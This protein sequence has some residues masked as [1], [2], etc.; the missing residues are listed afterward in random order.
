MLKHLYFIVFF[1]TFSCQKEIPLFK[2]IPHKHSNISFQNKLENTSQLNILNYLYFYNGA[3]I[4]AGDFNNDGLA[5]LYFVSNQNDDKLYINEGKL[6]FKDVS[7]EAGI[8]M[9]NKWATGVT[10]V[11]INNDGLLDIYICLVGAYSES[12]NILYVNKG[13][14]NGIPR[15]ENEAEKYGLAVSSYAT[16][17]VFFDFDLDDDLDMFLLNHSVHPNRTYGKGSLREIYNEES[18]DVLFE[19]IDGKFSDV[20]KEKGIFQGKT[21]YGLGV[22]ISDINNDGYPDIYVGN[23]FFEN[24]YLYIN[25]KGASFIDLISTQ[26]ASLGHT[27]HYS[28][29][30]SIADINNDG[31]PDIISL[32]MLPEDLHTYKISGL[33]FSFPI[34]DQYLKNGY[35]PQ[36]MQNTLHLNNG[37]EN[38][39]ETAFMSGIAATEWSWS[40]LIADFNNDGY[41]DLYITNGILGATNN[42]DFINFISNEKIQRKI[43]KGL[44]QDDFQLF[45]DIPKREAVNYFYRNKGDNTF[46]DVTKN[47]TNPE[48]S[49]S[50]GAVYTDLD[51]D[52]DLDIV[53]NNINE[54]AYLL[55][56]TSNDTSTTNYLKILFNGSKKNRLAIGAKVIAYLD[57][58]PL[59]YEN[60]TTRG[61]LSAVEPKLHIGLGASK[62]LDSLLVIWPDGLYEKKYNISPNRELVVNHSEAIQKNYY[63]NFPLTNR[64][65]LSNIES[66]LTFQHKDAYTLDF[67]KNPLIPFALSN[68]GPK[69]TVGDINS[70]GLDD[71]FICGGKAQAS[72]LFVQQPDGA[73]KSVQKEM[74]QESQLHEDTSGLF[75][76]ANGDDLLDLIVVSGGNEFN[77]GPAITPRL[78]INKNGILTEYKDAFIGTYTNASD[79]KS[80]D[81][82][83]DGDLDLAIASNTLPTAFGKTP[84]QFL[85]INDGKGNFTNMTAIIA[86]DFQFIGNVTQMSWADIDGNGYRDLIAVGLW[87]P[88]SVFLN[89]GSA[90]ELKNPESLKNTNGWW[91]SVK[92]EDFDQDGDLDIVAGNWGLNTRLSASTREPVTLYTQDFDD[93]GSE[94]SLVT[95]YYKGSETPFSTKEELAKQIPLINKKYLSFEAFA[96]ASLKEVFS[97]NKLENANKKQCFELASC[98]FENLGDFNFKKTKLP[99]LS[100]ISSV[101]AILAD[102]FNDDGFLDILL[103]GNNYEI[104]TQLGRLDA[105]H[106]TLLLNDKQGFFHAARDQHFNI[107]GPARSIEKLTIN[108]KVHYLIGVNNN[109]AIFLSKYE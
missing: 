69:N 11:D 65:Y 32:D 95:Y 33:E 26:N 8:S 42:M 48:A 9:S 25:Q 52:G 49:L 99:F 43:E 82:D 3:G 45:K 59:L 75:F 1:L 93:N 79:V 20:S 54:D 83:N 4:A 106:G 84:E 31:H 81:I 61:Y 87:M 47:W 90:L 36:Y 76:D 74:F 10:T 94:E 27:S 72:E 62:Q 63:Q 92:V 5:D 85:F 13:S 71:I 98:Y 101:N 41:K 107:T 70:D 22:S 56:N 7:A 102:D 37:N 108:N 19:N 23:D 105:S 60:Y 55:E 28:M 91:N 39:S 16:Q 58:Q 21:G 96:K 78:Y 50:N 77:S 17:A 12:K 40:P 68:C 97:E 24:D 38:F 57:G 51:N 73:F 89:N 88:I 80:V 46:T 35:G 34:Y 6:T 109:A 66:P 18:G 14:K 29:G 86:P 15:F 30:N 44:H 104:S 2:K 100:Q 53:V 103:A 64:T 67:N